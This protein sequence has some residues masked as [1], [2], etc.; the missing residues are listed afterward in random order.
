MAR[1]GKL[2]ALSSP[3]FDRRGVSLFWR[4]AGGK[5]ATAEDGCSS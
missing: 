1:V 3:E 2:V 5:Q 4:L